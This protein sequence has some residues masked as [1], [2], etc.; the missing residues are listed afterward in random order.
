MNNELIKR[1]NQSL[2]AR[3]KTWTDDALLR[4]C[5]TEIE[6]LSRLCQVTK[7]RIPTQTMEYEFGVHYRRGYEKG[8]AD[9]K[10]EIERLSKPY[11]PMDDD[12]RDDVHQSFTPSGTSSISDQYIAHTE[13]AVIARYNEQRGV[14]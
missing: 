14:K 11:V 8:K 12:A 2:I 3:P 7:I 6:R 9:A 4:D 5:R 10:A 13:S 1:I